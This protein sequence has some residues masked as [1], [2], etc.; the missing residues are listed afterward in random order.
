MGHI[1]GAHAEYVPNS[2]LVPGS[3]LVN[4]VQA[5]VL[6]T[7]AQVAECVEAL[8]ERLVARWCG[9]LAQRR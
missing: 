9:V 2:P 1:Q 6:K 4:T 3:P 7:A 5:Q 8:L